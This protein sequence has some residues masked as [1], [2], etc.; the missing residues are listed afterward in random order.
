M[1]IFYEVTAP[2]GAK[3]YLF[4]TAHLSDKKINT[5]S[6]EIKSAFETTT[7]LLVE[8]DVTSD[9]GQAMLQSAEKWN[10]KFG[11]AHRRWLASNENVEKV[12][13]ALATSCPTAKNLR[14]L[15]EYV[16][17]LMLALSLQSLRSGT[18]NSLDFLDANLIRMAKKREHTVVALEDVLTTFDRVI[19]VDDFSYEEQRR[20]LDIFIRSGDTSEMLTKLY[21]EAFGE[22]G[23]CLE[24]YVNQADVEEQERELLRRYYDVLITQRDKIMADNLAV[25]FLTGNAFVAVGCLHLNGIVE[26]Y[27]AKGY[28]VQ[29]VPITDRIY[30]VL[31]YYE[32]NYSRMVNTGI[33]FV[34][35]GVCAT[36]GLVISPYMLSLGLLLVAA[37]SA[38]YVVVETSLLAYEYL[39]EP[40]LDIE[41]LDRTKL[42]VSKASMFNRTLQVDKS[43]EELELIL[44]MLDRHS[45][46]L[47]LDVKAE[48]NIKSVRQY[49]GAMYRL[50][51]ALDSRMRERQ[52]ISQEEFDTVINHPG[53]PRELYRG[54]CYALA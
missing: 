15:V 29:P 9:M 6:L 33:I 34:L 12:V 53:D 49:K 22:H 44:E 31:D 47:F 7:S 28:T 51:E 2:N 54:G 3:S 39:T 14:Q 18:Q 4:G 5:L 13:R 8:M 26:K 38:S 46:A 48:D 30:P 10:I 41:S 43:Q 25:P 11:E 52:S 19:G 36:A 20:L 23:P 40:T 32:R 27:Q 24:D 35:A 21:L 17:P 37:A 45:P 16:P 42:G 50:A 1:P